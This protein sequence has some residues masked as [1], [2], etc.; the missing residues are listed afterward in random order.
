MPTHYIPAEIIIVSRPPSPIKQT[1]TGKDL[2]VRAAFVVPSTSA[3]MLGTARVW[4]KRW[5]DPSEEPIEVTRQNTPMRNLQVVGIDHRGEGGVAFKVI[6]DQGHYVDL[7]EPEFMEALLTGRIGKDGFIRGEYVW[8]VGGNQMRIVRI[9]SAIYNERLKA[10]ATTVVNGKNRVKTI[11]PADLCIGNLY[12]TPIA[13]KM[14]YAGRVRRVSDRK[15]L[16]AWYEHIA[17]VNALGQGVG[18]K[19]MT[20]T[21]TSIARKDLGRSWNPVHV[22]LLRIQNGFGEELSRDQ[23]QWPNGERI[24]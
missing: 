23:Y 11:R 16:F 4:A 18:T 21:S 12:D 3:K 5:M 19:R 10:G 13:G 8:S 14:S 24:R 20:I 17:P 22:P 15:L 2:Q 9:G 1:Y 6:T 7:R